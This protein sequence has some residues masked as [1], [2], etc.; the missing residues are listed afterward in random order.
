[1]PNLKLCKDCDS[2]EYC[3][4]SRICRHNSRSILEKEETKEQQTIAK[5]IEGILSLFQERNEK[6]GKDYLEFG[7]GAFN[8]FGKI[9][10]ESASDYERFAPLLLKYMKFRR[11]IKN[12]KKGGHQD[13]LDDDIIYTAILSE[14]DAK[15]NEKGRGQ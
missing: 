13:S 1:M 3:I 7:D 4:G 11:Y 2:S 6:Y 12:F 8:T 5:K 10:L 15:L 9:T 14:L